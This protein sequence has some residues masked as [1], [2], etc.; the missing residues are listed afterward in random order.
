[1]YRYLTRCLRQASSDHAKKINPDADANHCLSCPTCARRVSTR[2][3]V[4]RPTPQTQPLSFARHLAASAAS[5]PCTPSPVLVLRPLAI[6]KPN[7]A[8]FHSART[9]S[10]SA[11]PLQWTKR[12]TLPRQ[13]SLIVLVAP[14]FGLPDWACG[15]QTVSNTHR[16]HGE[17]TAAARRFGSRYRPIA[18]E[19]GRRPNSS[20]QH[21]TRLSKRMHATR[22]S[23]HLGL[24]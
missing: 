24:S 22:W 6:Y 23:F 10:F 16:N 4:E 14:S 17:Q 15:L 21:G 7:R 13:P 19:H 20:V 5:S 12:A 18:G 9:S 1:M 11:R 3:L 2:S 8:P